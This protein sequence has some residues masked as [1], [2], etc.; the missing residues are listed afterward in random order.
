MTRDSLFLLPPGFEAR[1]ERQYCPECAEVWG[2]LAYYPAIR[3]TLDVIYQPVSHP[4]SDLSA[5][6]GE[7]QWNCPTLILGDNS[8]D[9]AGVQTSNGLRYIDNA[10]DL[11]RYWAMLYGTA[12]PR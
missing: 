11:G 9:G 4:R 8:P 12:V 3:E 10:R 7:G 2:V 5:R 6:L 1:G